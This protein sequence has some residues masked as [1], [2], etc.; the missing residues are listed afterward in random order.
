MVIDE[1]T[2][3]YCL[4]D[5][6]NRLRALATHPEAQA[7]IDDFRAHL[8]RRLKDLLMPD[9]PPS[10]R[11]DVHPP[12]APGDGNPYGTQRPNGG[13]EKGPH[14]DRIRMVSVKTTPHSGNPVTWLSGV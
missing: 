3:L 6:C 2:S 10:T 1:L 8:V 13:T 5:N 12:C 11:I 14:T 4:I 9:A 7:A